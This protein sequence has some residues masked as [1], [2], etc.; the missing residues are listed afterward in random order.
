MSW[1]EF[2]Y[3]RELRVNNVLLIVSRDETMSAHCE[4]ISEWYLAHLYSGAQRPRMGNSATYVEVSYC[5]V[6]QS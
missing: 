6:G 4:R 2:I 1:S 3:V 5:Y